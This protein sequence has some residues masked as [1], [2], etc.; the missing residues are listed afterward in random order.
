MINSTVIR[1]FLTFS[2]N[3]CTYFELTGNVHKQHTKISICMDFTC[4]HHRLRVF[5]FSLHTQSHTHTH[6]YT[7]Q[8][9]LIY[10]YCNVC[11]A[12]P[13]REIMLLH[14]YIYIYIASVSVAL[15]GGGGQ[16]RIIIIIIIIGTA[17]NSVCVYI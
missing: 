7:Q 9:V 16:R 8:M 4:I 15:P 10:Q 17:F 3:F 1:V 14:A 5:F 12:S 11:H 6:K 13:V 2:N